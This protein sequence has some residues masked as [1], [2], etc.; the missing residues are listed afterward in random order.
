MLLSVADCYRSKSGSPMTFRLYPN[1]Y[2]NAKNPDEEKSETH[3]AVLI[4]SRPAA[5]RPGADCGQW[6][7]RYDGAYTVPPGMQHPRP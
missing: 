7:L 2:E 3:W 4:F 6:H 1:A 5:S